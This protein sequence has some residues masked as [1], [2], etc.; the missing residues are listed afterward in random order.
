MHLRRWRP[1]QLATMVTMPG[2]SCFSPKLGRNPNT[3]QVH[4][5]PSDGNIL[6]LGS[7]WEPWLRQARPLSV[8]GPL[9]DARLPQG[10]N[11]PACCDL[12]WPSCSQSM[13][14]SNDRHCYQ[15]F[16]SSADLSC[17]TTERKSWTGHGTVIQSL[18]HHCDVP[19]NRFW[20]HKKPQWRRS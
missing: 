19:C 18:H 6:R 20:R 10:F 13:T 1:L 15:A 4:P 11:H 8:C 17:E 2:A 9:P 16:S 3:S 14:S 5:A 7:I 12:A